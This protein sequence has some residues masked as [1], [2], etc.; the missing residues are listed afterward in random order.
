MG[1]KNRR[2]LKRGGIVRAREVASQ[3]ERETE[4]ERKTEI[5]IKLLQEVFTRYSCKIVIPNQFYLDKQEKKQSGRQPWG[6]VILCF[7]V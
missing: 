7:S 1:G 4:T 6:N 3:R 2:R 5:E